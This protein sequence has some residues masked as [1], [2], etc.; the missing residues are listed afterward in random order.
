M[1]KVHNFRSEFLKN[2]PYH[3]QH[4]SNEVIDQAYVTIQEYY[5][6]TCQLEDEA[7][8]LNNLETLFDLQKSYH[9]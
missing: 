9:K 7:K 4:T 6:R 8:Q 5:E 2:C 1:E 3:I